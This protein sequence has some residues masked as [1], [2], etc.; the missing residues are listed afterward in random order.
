M[1]FSLHM[2]KKFCVKCVL[3]QKCSL[4]VSSV[5]ERYMKKSK[6]ETPKRSLPF[7]W[8]QVRC[9]WVNTERRAGSKQNGFIDVPTLLLQT[10]RDPPMGST[11]LQQL[12]VQ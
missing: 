1:S 4:L 3:W 2:D 9:S 5:R 10:G 8:F 12:T 11:H 7:H 6:Q